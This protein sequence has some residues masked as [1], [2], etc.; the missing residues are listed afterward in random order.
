MLSLRDRYAKICMIN[1]D[2]RKLIHALDDEGNYNRVKRKSIIHT[3]FS[4]NFL[5]TLLFGTVLGCLFYYLQSLS[6]F[7]GIP[8]WCN[9]LATWHGVKTLENVPCTMQKS[10]TAMSTIVDFLTAMFLN[11]IRQR[12]YIAS[13][14]VTVYIRSSDTKPCVQSH[15]VTWHVV[16]YY[17]RHLSQFSNEFVGNLLLSASHWSRAEP[18]LTKRT[19]PS[20]WLFT[21]QA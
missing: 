2:I 14:A 11:T 13:I 6:W 5:K 4:T 9:S 8:R 7:V 21:L 17:S 19:R 1:A 20:E 15:D 18:N 16:T 10:R 3:D 12:N